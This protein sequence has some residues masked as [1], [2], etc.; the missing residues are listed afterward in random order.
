MLMA[1][2]L[3][4]SVAL[5]IGLSI[6]QKSLVDISTAT[7]VEQSSK[8]F[9]AAEAGIEQA[10]RGELNA[11]PNFPETDSS[12]FVQSTA[13]LPL[14]AISPNPQVGLEYPPLAKEEV[15]HVWLADPDSPLPNCDPVG[16]VC[17]AQ[18]SIE[19][20]WG[21]PSLSASPTFDKAAIEIKVVYYN[22]STLLY[23]AQAYYFDSNGSRISANGF[24]DASVISANGGCQTYS[25]NTTSGANSQFYCKQI[26]NSASLPAFPTGVN[27]KLILIR[28]RLLYNSN[29]QPVAVRATGTCGKDCSIP[30]QARIFVSRGTSGSAQRIIKLFQIEKVVPPYFDF[31]IFSAGEVNK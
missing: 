4:M 3:I 6:I 2:I 12:A 5:A 22:T 18:N 31:V 9:S 28:L 17:Y 26:L 16:Y 20:Y 11:S 7:K 21:D 27:I 19:I 25:I 15:A 13:R 1:L 8:A 30:P 14:T 23:G 24:V 10:L 29:S